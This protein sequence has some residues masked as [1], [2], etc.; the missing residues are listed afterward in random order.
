MNIISIFAKSF[1]KFD[2]IILILAAVNVYIY[3]ELRKTTDRLYRHFNPYDRTRN[4]SENGRKNLKNATKDA[5]QLTENELLD[6]RETMNSL[7]SWY[8]NLTTM[9]P[10]LGMLGTVVALIPMVNS[11]GTGDVSNFF[12]ALTSTAWGIIMALVFKTLDATVSYKIE[13]NEKHTE[14]LMFPKE[15]KEAL[16]SR[17]EDEEA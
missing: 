8:V 13:D 11:I 4:L 5:K 16:L 3:L 12:S 10:L 2:I 6:I 17:K 7:Y 1:F 15:D 9:F 14:Y